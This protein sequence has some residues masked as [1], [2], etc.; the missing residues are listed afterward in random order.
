MYPNEAIT[1]GSDNKLHVALVAAG[2]GYT[3]D[4][5]TTGSDYSS[6]P[7]RAKR[8]SR[9]ATACPLLH[10]ARSKLKR[11]D[12][13]AFTPSPRFEHEK[14]VSLRGLIGS[15]LVLAA[16]IGYGVVAAERFFHAKPSVSQVQQQPDDEPIDFVESAIVFRKND[17]NLVPTEFF[18][19]ES[20]FRVRAFVVHVTEQDRALRDIEEVDMRPCDVSSWAGWLGEK[21]FCPARPLRVRGRYQSPSYTFSRFDIIACSDD[22]PYTSA[23]GSGSVVKCA[24]PAAIDSVIAN[25]RFNLLQRFGAAP[26]RKASWEAHMY[27]VNPTQWTLYEQSYA[28]RRINLN[29]DFFRTWATSVHHTME[30]IS[31]KRMMQLRTPHAAG[32]N[33]VL[34]LFIRLGSF[35]VV[36]DQQMQTSMDLLGQ[37]WAFFGLVLSVL[38]LYFLRFNERRFYDQNP[39]WDGVDSQF[40]SR[41]T[42]MAE[43]GGERLSS[44]LENMRTGD[45]HAPTRLPGKSEAWKCVTSRA[46]DNKKKR[47]FMARLFRQSISP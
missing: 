2:E 22:H 31:E 42:R 43:V 44:K 30:M 45:D 4:T 26:G 10:A 23:D 15:V 38:A 5:N 7:S 29:A 14:Q 13:F 25:G 47:P 40:R 20:F 36:E 37:L 11:F 17:Q 34:T 33:Y 21:A 32:G 9:L 1:A 18:R 3:G 8:T 27:L 12:L 16:V 35:N 46:F 41:L 39:G 28:V 24:D 19:N 6:P